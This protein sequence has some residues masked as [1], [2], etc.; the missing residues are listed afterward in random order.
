M[1]GK[2]GRVSK[3]TVESKCRRCYA[4]ARE[5]Q[6]VRSVHC[7]YMTVSPSISNMNCNANIRAQVVRSYP[8]YISMSLRPILR[9][10]AEKHRDGRQHH[11]SSNADIT[12]LLAHAGPTPRWPN[13][14]VR[15][16]LILDPGP[17]IATELISDEDLEELYQ[18]IPAA[19][20]AH[21]GPQ[22]FH[23][24]TT[25]QHSTWHF[26]DRFCQMVLR[27]GDAGYDS[28]RESDLFKAM[29]TRAANSVRLKNW[30]N[31]L[32]NSRSDWLERLDP[33]KCFRRTCKL[34]H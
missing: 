3:Q 10:P 18:D 21:F 30:R 17:L 15:A 9:L 28:F 32:S 20:V 2:D 19:M 1:A 8:L 33:G 11:M 16:R 6:D 34:V 27:S 5:P 22:I 25:L 12:R 7:K 13:P 14:T 24:L 4:A 23:Q 29:K 31:H 26:Y